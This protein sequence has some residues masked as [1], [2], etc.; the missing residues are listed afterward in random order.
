MQQDQNSGFN[1]FNFPYIAQTEIK[2]NNQTSTR[3]ELIALNSKI[4][5]PVLL[6]KL[7][8]KPLKSNSLNVSIIF[9]IDFALT[10]MLF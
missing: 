4:E 3:T 5:E 6:L 2:L 1:T 7:P 10:A 8:F 9:K